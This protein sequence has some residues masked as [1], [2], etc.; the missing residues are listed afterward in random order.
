MGR[1]SLDT[2]A[3][4]IQSTLK[5]RIARYY[6]LQRDT[7]TPLL[8][9][10]LADALKLHEEGLQ[11]LELITVEQ[12]GALDKFK[13]LDEVDDRLTGHWERLH[14]DMK[15]RAAL[16]AN[17]FC[18]QQF[19]TV[20]LLSD[21][22]GLPPKPLSQWFS[23]R[24]ATI[25]KHYSATDKSDTDADSYE[26]TV[27]QPLEEL[28]L[29]RYHVEKR[30]RTAATVPSYPTGDVHRLIDQ[31]DWKD[32]AATL[33]NDREL[34]VTLFS[35]EPVEPGLWDDN[36]SKLAL[37]LID[38]IQGK[39]YARISSP[40]L[41]V[42]N[43]RARDLSAK[44]AA[45]NTHQPSGH[46]PSPATTQHGEVSPAAT[47]AKN[48]YHKAVR[49]LRLGGKGPGLRCLDRPDPSAAS[50]GASL[51]STAHLIDLREKVE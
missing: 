15:S 31:C 44:K 30:M 28:M 12:D 46:Q 41:Y 6:F 20:K 5:K 14:G 29:N 22:G 34:A 36:T 33:A 9:K 4:E 23:D 10:E 43:K 45:Q 47:A 21:Y 17:M 25:E 11:H 13:V 16:V 49:R 1:K 27:V 37:R 18:Y 32:L 2:A 26:K 7:L 48:I 3:Q 35:A 19:L 38:D 42:A 39:Y 8:H 51:D 24:I 40:S 50:T